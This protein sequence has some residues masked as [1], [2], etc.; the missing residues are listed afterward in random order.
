MRNL[1]EMIVSGY[2][3]ENFTENEQKD[4]VSEEIEMGIKESGWTGKQFFFKG[5]SS[6]ADH[7][8]VLC[9]LFLLYV[10]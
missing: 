2:E 1:F 9:P 3:N 7:M 6:F 5:S 10:L 4:L 8:A